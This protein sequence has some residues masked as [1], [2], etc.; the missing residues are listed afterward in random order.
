MTQN[1]YTSRILDTISN[2]NCT[3]NA[4][5]GNVDTNSTYNTYNSTIRDFTN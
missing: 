2:I 5:Q 4:L 1:K 3:Y